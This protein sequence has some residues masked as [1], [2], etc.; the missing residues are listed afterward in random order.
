M[1][2]VE[3]CG[4]LERNNREVLELEDFIEADIAVLQDTRAPESSKAFDAELKP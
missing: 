2:S 4:R 3:E 1:I